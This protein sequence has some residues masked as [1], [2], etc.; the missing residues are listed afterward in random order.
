MN[1]LR[2]VDTHCHLESDEF[3]I[4][5]PQ[6]ISRASASGVDMITSAITLEALPEGLRLA[7]NYPC[8][9]AAIGLDPR[10]CGDL[11]TVLRY[12]RGSSSRIVAVGETGLDYYFTREHELRKEQEECMRAMISVAREL[13]LPIQIHSRSAGKAALDILRDCEASQV[14]MHAFDGKASLAREASKEL[15]Y[16]FSIPT[17]VVRSPQKRNLVKAV[18]YERL[19]VETDSPVLGPDLTGRNEPANVWIALREIGAILGRE[20]EEV[21]SIVL[22]NTLRLYNRIHVK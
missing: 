14:Q 4:D 3:R 2:V 8:V 7:E 10:R 20:E 12:V 11:Q 13:G 19:L 1:G 22:E 18:E 5:L 15:G 21:R 16:Y 17:S 9:H 6:V